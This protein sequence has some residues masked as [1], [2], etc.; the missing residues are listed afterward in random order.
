MIEYECAACAGTFESDLPDEEAVAEFERLFGRHYPG[1]DM[2]I[3]CDPCHRAMMSKLEDAGLIDE[4]GSVK[5]GAHRF[6]AS[7]H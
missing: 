1:E 5:P 4:D 6:G 7:L 3:V 2:A